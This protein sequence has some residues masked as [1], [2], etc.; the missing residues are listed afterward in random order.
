MA[1]SAWTRIQVSTP[2][3]LPSFFQYSQAL[4]D[5]SMNGDWSM[6]PPSDDS[7]TSGLDE[8]STNGPW[9]YLDVA[10]EMHCHCGSGPLVV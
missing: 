5:E 4:P 1:S 8:V 9:G 3:A 2:I 10:T 7:H 6:E